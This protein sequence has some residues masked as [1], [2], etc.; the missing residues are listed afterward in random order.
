MTRRGSLVNILATQKKSI[1][2]F[3]TVVDVLA[4]KHKSCRIFLVGTENL[5]LINP[6]VRN[7]VFAYL[8]RK[9]LVS[10]AHSGLKSETH[11]FYV[12]KAY[13]KGDVFINIWM[14]AFSS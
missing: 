1:I 12:Q 6:S 5:T 13:L 2:G 4:T 14:V 7:S 11:I 3:E 8:F 9:K 10:A